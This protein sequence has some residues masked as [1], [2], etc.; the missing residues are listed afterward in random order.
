MYSSFILLPEFTEM[1]RAAGYGFHASVTQAG[2]FLLPSTVAMLVVSPLAGRLAGRVGSRVPLILG[3]ITTSVSFA[4]LAVAH[5]HPWEIYVGS[6]LLGAGIGLAFASLA[7][8]IV[9]AVRPD[10]TGVATGMNTVMRS[11][12][13]S[14]GSQIVA[15]IIAGTVV[16]TAL[17]T[18]H[19]FTI[20]FAVA[21]VACG[22]A[23]LAS[24]A[25]P[26]P[27]RHTPGRAPALA[28]DAA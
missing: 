11:I 24:L 27:T 21:A 7:N 9:E 15:S 12:G 26:R 19:G 23:A 17:P 5:S 28:A 10:Q 20:A 6:A 2:L 22:L 1:P 16:G 13:G 3:S 8:L 25:V 18:E 4:W 14:V